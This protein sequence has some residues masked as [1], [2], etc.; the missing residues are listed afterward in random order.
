M[1]LNKI[2]SLVVGFIVVILLFILIARQFRTSQTTSTRT[3]TIS[4]SPSISPTAASGGF[5]PFSW[6]SSSTPT[7][8]TKPSVGTLPTT[9]K[10]S[11]YKT[12]PTT[13][14]DSSYKPNTI[15][16]NDNRVVTKTPTPTYAQYTQTKQRV[17][18]QPNEI[19]QTG[20]GT[21]VMIFTSLATAA[22]VYLKK[23]S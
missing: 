15:N 17:I 8:T 20:A 12:T 5:D 13:I 10:I 7:P 6:F 14:A 11:V 21:M 18:V 4:I 9:T 1:E 3:Q 19:P 22:G 23:I 16:E 2:I